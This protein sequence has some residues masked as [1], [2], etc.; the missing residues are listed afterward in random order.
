MTT[1]QQGLPTDDVTESFSVVPLN[2]NPS[3][4]DRDSGTATVASRTPSEM[5]ASLQAP[6]E[7]GGSGSQSGARVM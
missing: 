6:E 4:R 1:V 2:E 7:S 5:N 3:M